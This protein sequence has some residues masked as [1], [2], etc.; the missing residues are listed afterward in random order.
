L[1]AVETEKS[2]EQRESIYNTIHYTYVNRG[3]VKGIRR[4]D[5]NI[6]CRKEEIEGIGLAEGKESR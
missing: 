6:G 5:W 1:T 4:E 2:E 3:C